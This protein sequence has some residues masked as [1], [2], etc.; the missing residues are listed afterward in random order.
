MTRFMDP[1]EDVELGML[2]KMHTGGAH[3]A[4]L[5]AVRVPRDLLTRISEYGRPRGMTVAEVLTVGAEQLIET[6]GDAP[7]E[8]E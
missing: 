6:T 7:P 1:E 5:I 3:A 2:V 8:D 4:A